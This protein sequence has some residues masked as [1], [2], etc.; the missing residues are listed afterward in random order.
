[1]TIASPEKITGRRDTK[2][3][4][5]RRN[6]LEAA[7]RLFQEKGY[8]GTSMSEIAEAAGVSRKTIFN[9]C[10]SKETIVLNLVDVFIGEHMPEWLERDVPVYGD[11]RDILTEDVGE[12]LDEIAAHRWLLTLA[13]NHTSFFSFGRTEFVAATLRT[14]IGARERRVAAVQRKGGIRAD[15]PAGE[16][17]RY[18]ETLRDLAVHN[19]LSDPDSE[20][21]DLHRLFDNAMAVLIR[22]LQPVA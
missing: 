17:S 7:E 9:Y 6:I 4:A 18:Y 16:I 1:M 21:E 14:N 5:V 19:W 15:I 12:R 2:K 3:A 13:A 8:D 10:E 11:A 20:P 22:G